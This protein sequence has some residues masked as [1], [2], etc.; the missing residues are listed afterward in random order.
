MLDAEPVALAVD[1]GLI[2][3]VLVDSGRPRSWFL[4]AV[5]RSRSPGSW[6][7]DGSAKVRTNDALLFLRAADE[8]ESRR[9]HRRKD[10]SGAVP[11]AEIAPHLARH[12]V[13]VTVR[14]LPVQA[15]DVAETLRRHAALFGADMLVMV[16]TCIP[17]CARW[18]SAER[19]SRFL[20]TPRRCRFL[21]Y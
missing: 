20:K 6:S 16:L 8:V 9:G 13:N 21:S 3:A 2:E 11:G 14:D 12:G 7:W 4:P 17:A 5:G 10:L 15:G 18:C 19:R 1:R